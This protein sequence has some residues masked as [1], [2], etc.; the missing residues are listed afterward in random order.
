MPPSPFS[1]ALVKSV[2]LGAGAPLG[3]PLAGQISGIDKRPVPQITVRDPGDRL[4]GAGSAVVGD[5]IVERQHH[6]GQRQALY[7]VAVEELSHW[8]QELGRDM[9]AGS[10]GENVT[11]Q[12]IDVDRFVIGATVLA[13]AAPAPTALFDHRAASR[14]ATR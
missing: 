9:P 3:P 4:T 2:N 1:L 10:F 7:L 11:T 6:G 13:G 14:R 8:A 5:V 12:G